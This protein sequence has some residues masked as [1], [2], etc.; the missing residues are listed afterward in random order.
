MHLSVRRY[1]RGKHVCYSRTQ[2]LLTN[3][4]AVVSDLIKAYAEA[5]CFRQSSSIRFM[6]NSVVFSQT[7]TIGISYDV[8]YTVCLRKNAPDL[9]SC[10]FVKYGQI[11]ITVGRNN[12]HTFGNVSVCVYFYLFNLLKKCTQST[13]FIY[14]F[15]FKQRL[16]SAKKTEF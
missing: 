6:I 14:H 3:F 8:N 15:V 1:Y 4:P 10:S 5:S 12:W 16:H 7:I 13:L 2:C 9:E 11:F